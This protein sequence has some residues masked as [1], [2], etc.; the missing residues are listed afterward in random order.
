LRAVAIEFN[1]PLLFRTAAEELAGIIRSSRVSRDDTQ[2]GLDG[3]TARSQIGREQLLSPGAGR[4]HEELQRHAIDGLRIEQ[5]QL[6][7][8]RLKVGSPNPP[9]PLPG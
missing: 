8:S 6:V 3:T 1:A 4:P 9:N 2:L 5:L 7:V